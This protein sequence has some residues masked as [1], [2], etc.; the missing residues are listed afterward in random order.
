MSTGHNSGEEELK[1]LELAGKAL[2]DSAFDFFPAG[3]DTI[4]ATLEWIMVYMAKYPQVQSDVQSEIDDVVGRD[5][6][7]T[8]NDRDNLP[9]TQSCLLEIQR[10]ASAVPFAVP[11]STTQ[12]TVLDGYYV[13]KDMLVFVNLYSAHYD[14]EVWHQPD[15]FNPRRFLAH[16]GTLDEEKTK[17]AIPFSLGPRRCPGRNV[18]RIK[19]FMYFATFLHQL[20]FSC[21]DGQKVSLEASSQFPR[22]PQEFKVQIDPR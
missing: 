17:L 18:A 22:R 12:D 15:I 8:L 4:L 1:R 7:P 11:H 16:D 6:L 13:P 21:P 10:Y 14:P 9:L 20:N 19:M 5:R 2:Y 3:T